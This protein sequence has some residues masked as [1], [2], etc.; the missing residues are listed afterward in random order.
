[1]LR[2]GSFL[3]FVLFSV[4]VLAQ[5]GSKVAQVIKGKVVDSSGNQAISYTNIGLEGTL[6]G[7]AS[8]AEGNFELKIPEDMVSKNIYF[9]AVGYQNRQFPVNELFGKDFNVI[10]MVAQSYDVG[11]VDVEAQ[12][13]VLIRILRMASEDIRYNYGDGPFNLHLSYLRQ[14]TINDSIKKETSADLLVY[15]KTG[16]SDPSPLNAYRSRKYRVDMKSS[17]YS[18][19]SNL[20]KIDE[21]LDLDWVRSSGGILNPALLSDYKLSLL[22]QPTID[23]KEY[24]IIS[25]KQVLPTLEGSGDF[26]ATAFEGTITISKEDYSVYNITGKVKSPK[27]NRQ[28]RSLAVAD[29]NTN[30]LSNMSYDFSV[31]YRDLLINQITLNKT[32]SYKGDLYQENTVMKLTRAHA[33]NLVVLNSRDYF[34]GE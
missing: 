8:D 32:Y 23:G 7:T 16:Y 14:T 27:N 13:M 21:M 31:D 19:A 33:N 30:F 10:K 5:G 29:S 24:W 17:E 2:V 28:D 22:S 25:F 6:Y 18:F 34:P 4:S 26:Y 12:N 9:S 15:D 1:M 3:I 20:L 11:S